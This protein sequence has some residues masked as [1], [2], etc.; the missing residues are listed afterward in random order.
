MDVRCRK[1]L[2][3][4]G[5]TSVAFG[6]DNDEGRPRLEFDTFLEPYSTRNEC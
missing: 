5:T 2:Y 4:A 6:G 3:A 1:G